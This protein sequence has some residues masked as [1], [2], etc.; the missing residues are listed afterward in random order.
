MEPLNNFIPCCHLMNS[1]ITNKTSAK[2]LTVLLFASI[3]MGSVYAGNMFTAQGQ[4]AGGQ[5]PDP[6]IPLSFFLKLGN[7]QS[8]SEAATQAASNGTGTKNITVTVNVQQGPS[9]KPISL[10]ISAVVPQNVNP[11]DMQLCASLSGGQEMCQP[12]SQ[13]AQNI[14]LSSS[15]NTS[16]QTVPQAYD[17][18]EKGN[19]VSI[20][21]G[22]L[23]Q[24]A[25]AQLI[26]VN[27]TTL[28][29]PITVIVPITVE[30][31]NAQICA[32]VASSGAQ[33]CQQIVLN[34]TQTA[35][36]PVNVDLTNPTTPTVTALTAQVPSTQQLSSP[37]GTTATDNAT[38]TPSS[39]ATNET[40][41]DGG[42]GTTSNETSTE[43]N[44]A[45]TQETTEP[46]PE[47]TT[48]DSTEDKYKD[49]DKDKEDTTSP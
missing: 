29:I 42:D 26:S 45:T 44:T 49:K 34:P 25:E 7:N 33:T 18:G 28:N 39:T 17:N 4:S 19:I 48:Q 13:S 47:S 11:E 24:T 38:T 46:Q 37:T 1:N 14:D 5:Q 31:Q 21:T 41:S 3:A 35:Y 40:S 10:P 43:T 23:I 9:G 12:V 20:L 8:T 36:T 22:S 6:N 2:I 32:T 30:I 16:A 27:N 15:A